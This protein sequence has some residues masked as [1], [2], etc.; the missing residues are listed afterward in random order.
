L[1]EYFSTNF[2]FKIVE[3]KITTLRL[4]RLIHIRNLIAHRR[5]V[6][7]KTFIFKVGAKADAVGKHVNL[8]NTS[9]LD[10][11]LIS[12][13]VDIDHRASAK[14]NLPSISYS[15]MRQIAE[16]AGIVMEDWPDG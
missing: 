5:G 12:L 15:E 6:I 3:K 14:F 10:K 13:A 16:Q 8:P 7:D 4:N 1:D 2:G 9:F 11:W